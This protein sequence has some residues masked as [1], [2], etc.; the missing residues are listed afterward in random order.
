MNAWRTDLRAKLNQAGFWPI[1]VYN[2][3]LKTWLN[4]WEQELSRGNHFQITHLIP[5]YLAVKF[6]GSGLPFLFKLEY[7]IKDATQI[8]LVF[9]YANNPKKF[10]DNLDLSQRLDRIN[11]IH[12]LH[13]VNHVDDWEWTEEEWFEAPECFE[14]ELV[15]ERL[16]NSFI[17][18]LI[19]R[20]PNLAK[21]AE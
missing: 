20:H 21:D 6:K 8:V 15:M 17:Q 10:P 13:N 1:D 16:N 19:K 5:G 12:Q 3:Q 4:L 2:E 14:E 18:F 11:D 9:T 7:R